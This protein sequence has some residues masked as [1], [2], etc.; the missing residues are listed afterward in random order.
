MDEP[1][2]M[3]TEKQ[4]WMKPFFAIWS[5][6]ALSLLGSQLVQFALVW[7]LTQ[8]TGSATVLA[9]ATLAAMLPRILLGPLSGVLV[10]RWD[11]RRVI[12]GADGLTALATVVLAALFWS[13][14]IQYW[15]VYVLMFFRSAMGGLQWPAMEA[16]TSLMA[17]KEYLAR[18]QGLN[19]MLAGLMNIGAAPLGAL[20]LGLLPMQGVLAVD[21]GTALL[22]I[23]PL[24][25]VGIPQPERSAASE[26]KSSSISAEMAAG[27]RYL[28]AW[29]GLLMIA[30]MATVVNLVLV[31]TSA[32]QP[33][34]VTEHFKGQAFHLAWLES[35][36]GF[37][38]VAGGLTLSAWGGF[39]RRVLTSLVGL[40]VL[41]ASVAALGLV[42]AQGFWMAVGCMF[43]VGFSNPMVDGPLFAV[44]QAV[45]KPEMQG[46]V[47]TLISSMAG[48]MSPLGLIV[49]GPLADAFGVRVW[50][51]VGGVVTALLG[52]GAL[53]IPAIVGIEGDGAV[54]VNQ[55]PGL[56]GAQAESCGD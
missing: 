55:S 14:E 49:A 8:E 38:V 56:G 3:K 19:R 11:R 51:V 6:Q 54:V 30:V 1:S 10:D 5:G 2:V 9:T 33:I 41:G 35:A 13:G 42:P 25:F 50:F 23:V 20:L 37:G 27:F 46:R 34:L 44:M 17:P 21:V 29:P 40:F 48:A 26:T 53:L 36:W 7:W 16:S 4:G 31:P 45:V 47:F 32:L 18:I 43:V 28:W 52:V 12:L 22:A 24:L 15:H 39:K